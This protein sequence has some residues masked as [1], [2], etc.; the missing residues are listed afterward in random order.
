M[1]KLLDAMQTI[2]TSSEKIS[3][4]IDTINSLADQTS[5]L[6]LNAS[7]EA[8]RAGEAGRGFAVVADEISKLSQAS[9]DASRTITD[10]IQN[11]NNAVEAGTKMA[12]TTAITL[13]NGVVNSTRTQEEI[14]QITEFVKTQKEAV[15][16]IKNEINEIANVIETNAAS[17]EENAAISDELI[18]CANE[19]KETVDQFTLKQ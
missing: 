4:I 2:R 14:N 15:N 9:A 18:S 10:L 13:N 12:D 1:K 3:E 5:L 16:S 6:A 7:I 17:S 19:L 11:S 8:A